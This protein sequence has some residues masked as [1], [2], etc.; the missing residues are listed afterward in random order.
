MKETIEE[1]LD[2]Y[3]QLKS[4]YEDFISEHQIIISDRKDAIPSPKNG[5]PLMQSIEIPNRSELIEAI[6]KRLSFTF[7][8]EELSDFIIEKPINL[9]MARTF[10]KNLSTSLDASICPVCALKPSLGIL[11]QDNIKNLFCTGCETE[12]R[13]K[14]IGC[15]HCG[16][17]EGEKI[18]I[19][20]VKDQEGYRVEACTSCGSYI[21]VIDSRLIPDIP[22]D[23]AD[24]KSIALDVIAQDKGFA[25]RSP[26]AIGLMGS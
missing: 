16:E 26:N 9:Y 14:R 21:K 18:D 24:I 19:I 20:Y 8:M 3:K 7:P 11:K 25:R 5:E 13:W 2:V 15:P 6:K 10:N 12:W 23:I 4:I 1:L 17:L 22:A